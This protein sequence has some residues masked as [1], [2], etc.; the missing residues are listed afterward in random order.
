MM[1]AYNVVRFKV[2]AGQEQKFVEAHRNLPDIA[3]MR[4]GA[5][6]KTGDRTYCFIGKWDNFDDIAGA[7]P[8]MIGIL[9][10]FRNMLEDL[11]GGLGVTDPIS[12]NAV[13]EFGAGKG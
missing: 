6:I 13:V 7:R 11:G 10:G 12:G 5:L 4:D 9:D 8:K 3:G 1:T 2:K